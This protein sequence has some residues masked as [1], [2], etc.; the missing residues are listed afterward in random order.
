MSEIAA[1]LDSELSVATSMLNRLV[2]KQLVERFHDTTDR[3]VVTCRLTDQGREEV[4]RFWRLG[5]KGI[6]TLANLLTLEE[7]RLVV[8][9]VETLSGAL[10]RQLTRSKGKEEEDSE[11]TH[12]HASS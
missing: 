5:R 11:Q 1:H 2:S 10:K 7:L 9:A 8:H 6:E 4:E 3:R 12:R